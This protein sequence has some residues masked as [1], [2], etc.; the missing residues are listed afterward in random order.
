MARHAMA[1]IGLK[2]S[3]LKYHRMIMLMNARSTMKL[4]RVVRMMPRIGE[5]LQTSVTGLNLSRM[6]SSTQPT[7]SNGCV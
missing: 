5:S 1:T 2:L 4:L 6:L 3:I 7:E